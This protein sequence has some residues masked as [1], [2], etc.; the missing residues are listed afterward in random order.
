MRPYQVQPIRARV[1]LRAMAINVYTTFPKPPALQEPH[2]QIVLYHIQD[3]HW[4]S[5]TSVQ[6]SSRFIL[7]P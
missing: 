2:H 6:R 5:L 7:Q 4:R 3:T 1:K